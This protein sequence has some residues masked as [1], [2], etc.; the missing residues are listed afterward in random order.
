MLKG[1][2]GQNLKLLDL[3]WLTKIEWKQA[4]NKFIGYLLLISIA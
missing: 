1:E 2:G 3:R 4:V